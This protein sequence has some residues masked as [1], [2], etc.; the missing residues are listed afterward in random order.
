MRFTVK[1]GGSILEAAPIRQGILSQVAQLRAEGNEVL[2]VHGG[3]KSLSRR[4]AQLNIPSRFVEGLRVTDAATLSVALMVLAGEVN[5]SLVADLER[6][7]ASALGL[8]GADAASVRCVP[9]SEAAGSADGLGFVGRPVSVN[10]SFFDLLLSQDIIPVVSSLALGPDFHFYNINADQM[11]SACA[12]GTGCQALVYLTDV[13]G[14]LGGNGTTVRSAGP[15]EIED[16]RN[17][18]VITGGMLPKTLSCLEA[19]ERGVPSVYVLPG[20][21]PGV[22]RR[23]VDGTL[24]EGTCISRRTKPQPRESHRRNAESAEKENDQ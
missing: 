11:A 17:R 21:S 3:G 6:L 5:K 9:L 12:W 20:A 7:G 13:A 16:L 15:A 22:L 10:K 19:L 14:V 2:V 1:L 4:L 18:H 24:S 8:C 23:V